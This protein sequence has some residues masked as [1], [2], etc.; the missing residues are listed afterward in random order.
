MFMAI[1]YCS[2]NHNNGHNMYLIKSDSYKIVGLSAQ[3]IQEGNK[4]VIRLI[5]TYILYVILLNFNSG[6][7]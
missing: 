1:N 2:W 6:F 7:E 4:K 5:I 3:V